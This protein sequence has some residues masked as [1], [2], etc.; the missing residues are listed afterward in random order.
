MSTLNQALAFIKP[1]VV[2]QKGVV[3]LIEEILDDAGIAT[4]ARRTWT[5][6]EMRASGV[7]DR[8]YAANARTGTCLDPA[9]LP[10][11]D[12]ARAE[13]A[14]AFED[15]WGKAVAAGRVVSGLV[16]LDRLGV[17]AEELNTRW[18]KYGA[19]KIAGGIYVSR[20]ADEGVYVLNGFYP[21][22]REI[23][24]ADGASILVLLVEFA[25]EHLS[26][27]RF[28]DEV[29]GATNPA[30]ADEESIRGLLH[31]RQ[32]AFGITVS[33]RENVIHAS[34]GAFEALCEKSLWLPELPLDRDPLWQALDGSGL[35]FD[36]LRAWRD[37]NPLLTLD[38][39]TA[40]LLDLLECLDTAPT[41]AK[42]RA[43]AVTHPGSPGLGCSWTGPGCIFSTTS[44]KG[45]P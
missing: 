13:F 6:G 11:D 41:A 31:D 33:Y 3:T 43:L 10:V 38:G 15:D 2:N 4:V 30:A 27:K 44:P 34:A 19:R 16:A 42:L 1:H 40:T 35:T 26:W 24:T 8:H 25:P 17:S 45:A 39:R 5:A 18:A 37:A 23:F 7:V 22:M 36:R 14:T 32:D 29:I 21:S 12:A 28:R 9:R 20:F